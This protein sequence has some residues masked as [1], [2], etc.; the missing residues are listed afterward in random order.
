MLRGNCP[1]KIDA[2]GRIKVPNSFRRYIEEKYGRE[3]FVTSLSGEFVRVY[4]M[5]EWLEVEKKIAAAPS[6]DPAITRFTNMVNYYGQAAAMDDQGRLL[7]H[8]VVRH[9]SGLDGLVAVLGHQVYIDIWSKE[10][11]ESLLKSQP[12]TDE[13]RVVLARLGL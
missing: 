7:I 8:P 12:I 10:K 4:P 11:F 5:P 9:A 6:I 2:K 1:A 3:F 13:H